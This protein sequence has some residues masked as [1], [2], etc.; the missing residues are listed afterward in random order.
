MLKSAR[1]KKQYPHNWKHAR[2]KE[3]KLENN[4]TEKE[5]SMT[6]TIAYYYG[7]ESHVTWYISTN[8]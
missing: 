7:N 8:S 6:F 5:K 3:L 1:E 4:W 2:A